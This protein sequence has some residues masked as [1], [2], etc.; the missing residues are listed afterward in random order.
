MSTREIIGQRD[1]RSHRKF[2]VPELSG[3]FLSLML[4]AEDTELLI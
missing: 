2:R 1:I 4:F 3:N